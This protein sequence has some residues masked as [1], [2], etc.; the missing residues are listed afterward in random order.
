MTKDQVAQ[1]IRD[2]FNSPNV[3]DS[4]LEPANLV[5][6][7]AV[8]GQGLISA[9]RRISHGDGESLGGLEGAATKIHEGLMAV[10]N[11]IENLAEAVRQQ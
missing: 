3:P 4:N 7:A 8:V 11:S 10:A 9:V 6:V 2:S 1:A 5:D